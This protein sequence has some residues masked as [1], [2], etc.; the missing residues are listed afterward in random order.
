MKYY[1]SK[2]I[3]GEFDTVIEQVTQ[4]LKAIGFGIVTTIDVK[5]TLHEKIQVNFKP[6]TILGACNPVFAYKALQ[7]EEKLGVLLPCNVVV[8]DQGEG[9]I[10]VVAMT[11]HELM[12]A[13]D[14]KA[15]QVFSEEINRQLIGL[16]DAL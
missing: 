5:K 14:N 13:I 6:Y 9:N 11:P 4:S 2:V 3:Q 12:Q 10:E 16:I 7:L 15:L 8:I 1:I